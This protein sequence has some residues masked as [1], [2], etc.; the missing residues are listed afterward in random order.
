MKKTQLLWLIFFV[1]LALFL[2]S[3]SDDKNYPETLIIGDK[4][5][6]TSYSLNE[7]IY[8]SLED[9]DSIDLNQ[10]GRFD[11][12]FKVISIPGGTGFTSET[13]I[14][15]NKNVQLALNDGMVKVFTKDDEV[16]LASEW[17]THENEYFAWSEEDEDWPFL[18]DVTGFPINFYIAYLVDGQQLGWLKIEADEG[19]EYQTIT[20]TLKEGVLARKI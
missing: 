13:V 17:S 15:P 7:E 16:T 6:T 1:E 8:A 4:T 19:P 9:A 2:F 18:E 14:E 12:I 3:C 10:D 5:V 20:F 11:L